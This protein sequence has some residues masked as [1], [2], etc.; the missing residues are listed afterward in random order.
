LTRT[1]TTVLRNGTTI[2]DLLLQEPGEDEKRK[3]AIEEVRPLVEMLFE[4]K[5][6]TKTVG[7]AAKKQLKIG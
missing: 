7:R 2:E 5:K 1:P 4:N 6:R 3:Q